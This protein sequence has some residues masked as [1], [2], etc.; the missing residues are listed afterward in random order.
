MLIVADSGRLLLLEP[1]CSLSV[2]LSEENMVEAANDSHNAGWCE[3]YLPSTC[4]LGVEHNRL[5]R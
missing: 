1:K 2:K 3:A 4:I 5:Q